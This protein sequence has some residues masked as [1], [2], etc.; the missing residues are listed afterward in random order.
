MRGGRARPVRLALLFCLGAAVL[1]G[2]ASFP[3][4]TSPLDRALETARQRGWQRHDIDTGA[5]DLVAFLPPR[6]AATTH[7]TLYIEGDGLAWRGRY[8]ASPD[9]TPRDP[10]AL[11]LALGD[12]AAAVAYLARPCQYNGGVSARGCDARLWTTHRLSDRVIAAMDAAMDHI[13]ARFGAARLTLIGYS[14]GGAAAAL[15]AARRSDID[16]L[17]TVAAPLDTAA[18]TAHHGVSPLSGSRN[19]ADVAPALAGLRQIH[20]MGA[21]DETVP[22]PTSA[23]YF[24][25]AGVLAARR[26]IADFDHACCWVEGWPRLLAVVAGR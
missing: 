25:R 19:P 9:P 4:V 15:L 2:C 8:R 16:L 11:R 17:V 14:G 18:W 13:K 5:L 20:L 3:L 23:R 22:P 26:M 1:A 6:P 21:D 10:V 7:L 24:D 12:P